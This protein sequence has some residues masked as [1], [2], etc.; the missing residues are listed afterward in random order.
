MNFLYIVSNILG[1]DMNNNKILDMDKRIYEYTTEPGILHIIRDFILGTPNYC[2]NR[3][4][5]EI[6]ERFNKNTCSGSCRFRTRL[7][8]GNLMII[9]QLIRLT[10]ETCEIC[11]KNPLSEYGHNAC[12]NCANENKHPIEFEYFHR[13]C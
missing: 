4:I 13:R 6:N 2:R 9:P 7:I 5:A 11:K 10:H 1:V 12:F 8:F 3:V